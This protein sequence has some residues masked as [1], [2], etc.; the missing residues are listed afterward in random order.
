[1]LTYRRSDD[2]VVIGCSD[3]DFVGCP[4]DHKS[5]S[6]YIFIMVGGAVSWKSVKQLLTVTSNMEAEYVACYEATKEAIW[7]RNFIFGLKIVES[8]LWPLTIYCDNATTVSFSQN[9][10]SFACAKY[11]DV[12]YQFVRE[13]VREHHTSMQHVSIG[14]ML[15][16]P[17]TKGLAVKVYHDHVKNIDLAES[18][19]VL[20]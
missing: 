11:F 12:K 20:S 19:D 13:K 2:L 5:T 14:C 6:G 1:M 17:L 9:N 10:K 15:T 16:N 7:L 3:S 8:I 18:F 4:D